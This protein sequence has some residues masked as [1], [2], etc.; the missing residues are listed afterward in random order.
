MKTTIITPV[1]IAI[2]AA[3]LIPLIIWMY[4]HTLFSALCGILTLF[5]LGLLKGIIF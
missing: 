5:V 3:S 4:H 1:A 2:A